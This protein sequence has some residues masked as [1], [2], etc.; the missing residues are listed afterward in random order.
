MII[1]CRK[2]DNLPRKKLNSLRSD[3]LSKDQEKENIWHGVNHWSV[4]GYPYAD[5]SV[6]LASIES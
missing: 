1:G 3:V 4:I 2:G 6:V 5:A